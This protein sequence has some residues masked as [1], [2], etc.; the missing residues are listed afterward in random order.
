MRYLIIAD[1]SGGHSLQLMSR[2]VDPKNIVVWED[3][4]KGQYCAKI[5]GVR[6]VDDLEELNG[7]KFDVVI[8]NPPY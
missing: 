8:G 1:P 6:V 5:R 2:G 4:P 3:T 7:M